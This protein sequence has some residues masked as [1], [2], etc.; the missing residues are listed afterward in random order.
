MVEIIVATVKR[1]NIQNGGAQKIHISILFF[2]T[3]NAFFPFMTTNFKFT[4]YF[5]IFNDNLFQQWRFPWNIKLN[6]A[7]ILI[8]TNL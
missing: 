8:F 6:V 4:E 3:L 1:H 5:Q 7:A 2:L